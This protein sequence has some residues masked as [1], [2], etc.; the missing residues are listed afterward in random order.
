MP[1]MQYEKYD[2]YVQNQT[3]L[4][5]LIVQRKAEREGREV[6]SEE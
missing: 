5:F 4:M 2:C 3:S 6:G 1:A